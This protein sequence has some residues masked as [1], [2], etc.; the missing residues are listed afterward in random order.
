VFYTSVEVVVAERLAKAFE[1]KYP[2]VKVQVERTGSERVLQRLAQEYASKIYAA[3]V[4]STSDAAHFI[5][6]KKEGILAP[7]LPEEVVQHFPQSQRE[8]DG[9][10]LPWRASLSVI[11]YNT[12]LVKPEEAPK[13]FKDLLDPKWAGRLVKAH[14][15]YSGTIVTAT[16]QTARDIGWDYFEK[17]SKQKV[18]QVQSS[19]EPPKKLAQ[20]ERRVMVDGSEYVALQMK[21]AG[22]PIEIVYA[23]EGSPMVVSPSAVLKNAANPNAARLFQS[24]MHS[25]EGQQLLIDIGGMRSFHAQTKNK[26][27]RKTLSEIKVMKED[28]E[29]VATQVEKIKERYTGYFGT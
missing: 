7:Y 29:A 15:S 11:A 4:V 8:A 21:E 17:L 2:G 6:W 1:T 23:V 20:G 26:P 18:M 22:E 14:P 19:T 9:M 27:G 5:N 16:F 24:Y 25:L 3:D 12:K 10:Y 13:G 28:P